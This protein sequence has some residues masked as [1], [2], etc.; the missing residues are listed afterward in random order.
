[1]ASWEVGSLAASQVSGQVD[2][3]L[4][5]CTQG[6]AGGAANP[7]AETSPSALSG[8]GVAP[9]VCPHPGA[10]LFPGTAQLRPL[11]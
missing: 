2:E 5:I 4:S 1:M 3:I 11:G 9:G 10:F 6:P 8:A 7:Y